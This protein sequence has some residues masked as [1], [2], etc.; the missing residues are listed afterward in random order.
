MRNTLKDVTENPLSMLIDAMALGASGAIERQKRDGQAELVNSSE[1]PT[2]IRDAGFRAAFEAAGGKFLEDRP[3]D[4]FQRVELPKG[5]KLQATGHSMWSELRDDKDRV[6]AS[7]FY[8]AAFYD[9]DAFLNAAYRYRIT[10]DYSEAIPPEV[11]VYRA[12]DG[13]K[14]LRR[15]TGER[16]SATNGWK[17]SACDAA[18]AWMAENFPE[19]GDCGA[20][21]S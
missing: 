10:R 16:A 3:T 12:M 2:N 21:W 4:L 11:S 19:W 20:Y 9:R 13:D 15:F 8:K 5:W 1:L 7:I 17:D 14:E 18:G 6:R